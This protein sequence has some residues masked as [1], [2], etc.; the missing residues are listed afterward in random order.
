MSELL[1]NEN[2]DKLIHKFSCKEA[3]HTK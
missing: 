3:H 1:R 2:F